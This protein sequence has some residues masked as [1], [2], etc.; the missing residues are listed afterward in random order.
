MLHN[1]ITY[2]Q[3]VSLFVAKLSH[4]CSFLSFFGALRREFV[5]KS[6]K[7]I[8]GALSEVIELSVLQIWSTVS[9]LV[10]DGVQVTEDSPR[11]IKC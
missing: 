3:A 5:V 6:E 8:S 4:D 2:R 10:L 9:V 11:Y 1:V 7:S